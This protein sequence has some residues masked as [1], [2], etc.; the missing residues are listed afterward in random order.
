[1]GIKVL[2]KDPDN[3]H[4][5]DTAA[6]QELLERS[7]WQF[8]T[9]LMR[10]L[11]AWVCSKAIQQQLPIKVAQGG[12]CQLC[13][14]AQLPHTADRSFSQGMSYLP[15]HTQYTHMNSKSTATLHAHHY[16]FSFEHL[17]FEHSTH[18]LTLPIS[19]KAKRAIHINLILVTLAGS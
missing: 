11:K 19:L 16:H 3:L 5:A 6:F 7:S 2:G 8:F 9:S 4:A 13:L 14:D 18:A 15:V 1:M 17:S 10:G 12:V